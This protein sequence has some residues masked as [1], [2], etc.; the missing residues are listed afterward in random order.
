MIIKIGPRLHTFFALLQEWSVMLREQ[1]IGQRKRVLNR[2]CSGCKSS[3]AF[4]TADNS[5]INRDDD[6]D[7]DGNDAAS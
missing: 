6:M 2:H 7:I 5:R 3:L 4:A 1:T